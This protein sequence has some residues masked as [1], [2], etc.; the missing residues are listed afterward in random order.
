[1]TCANITVFRRHCVIQARALEDP[2]G[3]FANQ[4][5][6]MSNFCAHYTTTAPEI[7][8]QTGGALDV[9]VLGAGTGMLIDRRGSAAAL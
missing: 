9:L 3:F 7:Y 8:R 1:M 5:E 4:F 2:C 6:T